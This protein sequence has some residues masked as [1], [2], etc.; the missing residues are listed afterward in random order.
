MVKNRIILVSIVCFSVAGF[1]GQPRQGKPPGGPRLKKSMTDA[2]K[3]KFFE[4]L[5]KPMLQIEERDRERKRLMRREAWKRLLRI[6]EWQWKIIKTKA[7]KVDILGW[8]MSRRASVVTD[9]KIGSSRWRRPSQR[10]D[11]WPP[12]PDKTLDELT[13]S[14]KIV[15]E[16]IDVLEDENSKDGEIRQKR[17]AL[18]HFREKARRE[19]AKARRELAEVLTTP[20]QEAVFLIIGCID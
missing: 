3:L 2:E 1:A 11:R 19:L 14:E 20:R 12:A 10:M 4:P 7:D 5:F 13:E 17:D 16:L 15:E 8:R 9:S 6:S 18:Q